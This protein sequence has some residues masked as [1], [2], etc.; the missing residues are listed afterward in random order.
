MVSFAV[1]TAAPL[2]AEL[3]PLAASEFSAALRA[4]SPATW[5]AVWLLAVV[6][7]EV[8]PAGKLLVWVP[9]AAPAEVLTQTS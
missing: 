4:E 6:G 9:L 2:E 5:E 8:V 7:P 3:L 1:L